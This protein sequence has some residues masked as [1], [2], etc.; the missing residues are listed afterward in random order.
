MTD[1]VTEWLW[2]MRLRLAHWL[3]GDRTFVA[4]VDIVGSFITRK[5][6]MGASIVKDIGVFTD[7]AEYWKTKQ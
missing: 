2:A 3:I 1:R 7:S 5:W 4:N 6:T